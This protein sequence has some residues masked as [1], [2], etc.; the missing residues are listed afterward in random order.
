[1]RAFEQRPDDFDLAVLDAVMPV[2]SG[3]EVFTAMR[4]TRPDIP[5]LFASG[6]SYR[7][8]ELGDISPDKYDL[9]AKPFRAVELL[10][11]VRTMLDRTR[12]HRPQ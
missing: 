2:R 12:V 7:V 5:V 6:Y 3:K 9:V 8:L 4:A 10:G 11:K 1:V